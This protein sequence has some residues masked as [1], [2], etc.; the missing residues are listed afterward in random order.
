VTEA[1]NKHADK[2][3]GNV[4]FSNEVICIAGKNNQKSST[5]NLF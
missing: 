3:S 2:N 1:A 4:K 5:S